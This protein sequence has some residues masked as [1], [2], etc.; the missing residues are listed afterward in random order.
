MGP[1][2]LRPT[3][4]R[5]RRAETNA[6]LSFGSGLAAGC[7]VAAFIGVPLLVVLGVIAAIVRPGPAVMHPALWTLLVVASCWVV[8]LVVGLVLTAV[9]RRQVAES[10]PRQEPSDRRR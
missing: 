2:S 1:I 10:A 5:T 8:L 4:L 7:L 3:A 6:A 9:G